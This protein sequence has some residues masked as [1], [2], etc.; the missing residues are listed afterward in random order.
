[1]SPG[2]LGEGWGQNNLTGALTVNSIW[3]G[4]PN[5]VAKSFNEKYREIVCI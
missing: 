1:M 4:S 3:G 2:V 5:P